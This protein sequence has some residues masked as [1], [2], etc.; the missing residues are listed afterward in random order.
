MAMKFLAYLRSLA[1]RFFHRSQMADEMRGAGF[2]HPAPCG[3]SRAFRRRSFRGGTPRRI[4]FGGRE[5]FKEECHEA[6]GGTLVEGLLNDLRYAFRMLRKSPAFTI[7]AVLTLALAIGANAVVFAVLNALILRPLNVPQAQSLC[8]HRARS[9][10]SGSIAVL[11]RLSRSA[12]PQPQLRWSGS[13]YR[14]SRRAWI[15]A[16]IHP[17][18]GVTKRAGTI[19]THYAFGRILAVSF[20]A[21]MSTARTALPISCSATHIGITIFRM[22]LAWWATSFSSTSIPFTILGV[23]PPEFHGTLLFFTPISL[24]RW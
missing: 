8:G 17:A 24:C 22:I 5:K 3:R 7:T 9:Q 12:R 14:R 13:L 10:L 11:S 21:P 16:K 1:E 15:R 19:S 18:H 20:T 4:E 6:L 2:P 23:A